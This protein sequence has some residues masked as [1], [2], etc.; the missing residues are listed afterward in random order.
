MVYMDEWFCFDVDVDV[1]VIQ[2]REGYG[3]GKW[4][5]KSRYKE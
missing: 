5:G 4:L 1:D 3:D 2:G